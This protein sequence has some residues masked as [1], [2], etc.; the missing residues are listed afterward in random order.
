MK[1]GLLQKFFSLALVGVMTVS[2]VACGSDKGEVA[3]TASDQEVQEQEA[4]EPEA[5]ETGDE[6]E[7]VETTEAAL[8]AYEYPGPELF[9]T[10]LYQYL[11]DELSQGYDTADV[12]IP[13]P[14]IITEDESDKSDIKVWGDFWIYNYELNGET[15][16]CVSGGSY[17]GCIHIE[18]N[19]AGYVVTDFERV[20]DGSDY[21]PTAKK[22]FGDYYKDLVASSEDKEANDNLRAQIISNYVFANNL[23]I[24]EYKDYG[25][26]PVELP[27]QNIDTFYSAL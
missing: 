27:E 22:I 21:E 5:E 10:V 4:V 1:N 17:P 26:D 19:D 13:C 23:S 3:E 2:L 14:I 6:V 24:K 7:E 11:I 25:W 15:L 8:P 20:G 12:C 9:Y 16:E 18:S